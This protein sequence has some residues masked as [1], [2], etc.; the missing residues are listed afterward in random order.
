MLPNSLI[1][2]DF[3]LKHYRKLFIRFK[4]VI[5]PKKT[6]TTRVPRVVFGVP[7]NTL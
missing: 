2:I 6:G 5:K 1:L 4:M 7:P 3:Q